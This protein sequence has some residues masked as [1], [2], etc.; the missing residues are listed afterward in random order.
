[1]LSKIELVK[2]MDEIC[3]RINRE[4]GELYGLQSDV[5]TFLNDET[6]SDAL[7]GAYT[8]MDEFDDWITKFAD[9]GVERRGSRF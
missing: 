9:D 4:L 7:Q 5:T 6:Y 3:T 1:M 8:G 2:K